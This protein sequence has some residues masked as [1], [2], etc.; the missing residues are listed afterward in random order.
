MPSSRPFEITYRFNS[1]PR[2]HP[3]DMQN[4][5]LPVHEAALHLIELHF[6][7]AENSL[8]M[9][10]PDATPAEILSQ[11]ETLGITDIRVNRP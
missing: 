1:E 6:A 4:D 7:D 10:A 3:F 11:A 8:A 2:R 9:P 5:A